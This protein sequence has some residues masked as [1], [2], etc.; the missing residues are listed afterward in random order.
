MQPMHKLAS[1][2]S[3]ASLPA[4]Q[5]TPNLG[6]LGL[7]QLY[8]NQAAPPI[9]LPG[10]VQTFT[11]MVPWDSQT[12]FLVVLTTWPFTP[13]EGTDF[14]S[15]RKFLTGHINADANR[16]HPFANCTGERR[17]LRY[18]CHG[19]IVNASAASTDG[20]VGNKC[21]T[22]SFGQSLQEERRGSTEWFIVCGVSS[23]AGKVA[24][25]FSY[26]LPFS[27]GPA[28]KGRQGH[29]PTAAKMLDWGAVDRWSQ[30][31]SI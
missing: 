25:Q 29:V 21:L 17:C 23:E 19:G 13:K 30:S 7:N 1:T 3:S 5:P 16:V 4:H 27:A 10:G 14:E 28:Q 31:A 15:R 12:L 2:K 22:G 6:P 18:N 11:H 9:A 24:R 8:T 26:Q 20:S